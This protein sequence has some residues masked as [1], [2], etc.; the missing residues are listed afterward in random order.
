MKIFAKELFTLEGRKRG[1]LQ[2]IEMPKTCR[3]CTHPWLCLCLQKA[4]TK[5]YGPMNSSSQTLLL[6]SL[7]GGTL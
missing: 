2:E 3:R 4:G 1:E 7:G 6:P 5:L